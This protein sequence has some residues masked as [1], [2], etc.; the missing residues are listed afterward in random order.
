MAEAGTAAVLLPGAFYFLRETRK[1]PVEAFRAHGVPMVVATDFNP[2]SSPLGSPLLAMNLA[3]LC[4][5]LTPAE[6]FAGMTRH[7]APV[8]G[9]T[10]RGTV[11]AGARADLAC[12]DVA[13]PA[14]LA[15]WMGRNPC[16]AVFN[17]GVRQI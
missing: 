3:C 1:P 9:L 15:Y 10:D 6:A 4:F 17:G 7:A 13:S 16:T 14:E 8:L 11:T 12:W 2:G 5:G